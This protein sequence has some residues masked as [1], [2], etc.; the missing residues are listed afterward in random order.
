MPYAVCVWRLVRL[1]DMKLPVRKTLA[2]V[3]GALL[4]ASPAS[5]EVLF[6]AN[7]PTE[8]FVTGILRFALALTSLFLMVGVGQAWHQ[9]QNHGGNEERK[10]AA[11]VAFRDAVL[12]FLLIIAAGYAVPSAVNIAFAVINNGVSISL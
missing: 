3:S 8:T 11:H 12:F 9:L 7:A 10:A 6:T 1:T 2:V 4:T 5:A